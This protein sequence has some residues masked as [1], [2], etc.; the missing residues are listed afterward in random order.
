MVSGSGQEPPP[1]LQKKIWCEFMS[2]T[3][4]DMVLL[5]TVERIT[6]TESC[7]KNGDVPKS[8]F[9]KKGSLMP[10]A[11]TIFNLKIEFGSYHRNHLAP[12]FAAR[13]RRRGS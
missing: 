11:R 1:A 2:V 13:P 7:P 6:S 5:H 8:P 9:P 4:R 3:A 10:S 12:A